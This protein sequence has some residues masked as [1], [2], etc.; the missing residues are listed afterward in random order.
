[1]LTLSPV[2]CAVFL[3]HT[4]P[5]RGIM[6]RV[7]SGIDWVR[8]RYAAI[9]GRLARLAVLCFVLVLVYCGCTFGPSLLTPTGFLPEE[10]QGAFF[11]S[12]QLPDGASVAR[13]SEAV[14][15]VEAVLKQ[16]PE[17]RNVFAVI[18]YSIVDSVNEAN[19]AF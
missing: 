3:R 17:V 19:M 6:G 15:R 16:M 1:T 9:V 4:G 18:G 8:D 13:T 12:V 5:R 10:D 7:L 11:I 2:L 14:R